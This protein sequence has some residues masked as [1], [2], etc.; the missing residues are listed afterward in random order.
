MMLLGIAWSRSTWGAEV[1]VVCEARAFD[2]AQG[3][4]PAVVAWPSRTSATSEVPSVGRVCVVCSV[5]EGCSGG[6]AEI[7]S[8]MTGVARRESSCLGLSLGTLLPCARMGI[9]FYP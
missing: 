8:D 4:R 6:A 7:W 3:S 5:G 9:Y 2:G 1:V